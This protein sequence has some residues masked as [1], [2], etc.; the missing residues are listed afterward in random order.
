MD[1]INLSTGQKEC[2][3]QLASILS[4]DL[5]NPLNNIIGFVNLVE[6]LS[7]E[8]CNPEI[9][10]YLEIIRQEAEHAL[11]MINSLSAW[12]Q[13][14]QFDVSPDIKLS[15]KNILENTKKDYEKFSLGILNRN[16]FC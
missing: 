8:P 4:H 9:H 15:L 2:T 7:T 10:Q 5:K 16:N 1:D 14:H 13:D 11:N 12:C 3:R 6:A